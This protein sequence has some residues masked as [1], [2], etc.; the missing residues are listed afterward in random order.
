MHVH[1][2]NS[3]Q[4]LG[5]LFFIPAF[6]GGFLPTMIGIIPYAGTSFS[7][8]EMLKKYRAS[9]KVIWPPKKNPWG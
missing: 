7:T 5:T 2:R 6:Y 4:I 8:F 3:E 9:N 1:R